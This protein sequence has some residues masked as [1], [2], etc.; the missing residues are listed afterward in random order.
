M[1]SQA[2]SVAESEQ[3]SSLAFPKFEDPVAGGLRYLKSKRRKVFAFG[4]AYNLRSH[5]PLL[6]SLDE[7]EGMFSVCCFNYQMLTCV[8][9]HAHVA[10]HWLPVAYRHPADEDVGLPQV[11]LRRCRH[12]LV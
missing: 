7:V 12:E 2:V 6:R 8:A 9:P 1:R 11:C 5:S 10:H 3:F 4:D